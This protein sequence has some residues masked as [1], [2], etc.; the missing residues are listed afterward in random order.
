MKKLRIIF[1]SFMLAITFIA[2]AIYPS[3]GNVAVAQAATIK[4]N[5]NH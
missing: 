2:P 4:I 1:L 5:K 3:M